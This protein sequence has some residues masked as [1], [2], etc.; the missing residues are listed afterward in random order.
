MAEAD[1]ER[2]GQIGNL[3]STARAGANTALAGLGS[4]TVSAGNS[5]TAG[6]GGLFGQQAQIGQ[7][8]DIA[9]GQLG[10]QAG[11]GFGGLLFNL[12][13]TFSGGK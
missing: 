6:A 13:K 3:F 8:A 10:A 12:L 9:S 7:Q 2:A 4:S 11:A 1:R 5:A